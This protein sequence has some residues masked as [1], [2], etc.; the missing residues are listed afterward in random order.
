MNEDILK[1]VNDIINLGYFGYDDYG[2]YGLT[3]YYDREIKN[4]YAEKQ[5]F[6]QELKNSENKAEF[7]I[8]FSIDFAQ[9][10]LDELLDAVKKASSTEEVPADAVLIAAAA[11]V[12][13]TIHQDLTKDNAVFYAD[14]YADLEEDN[15]SWDKAYNRYLKDN[16]MSI[17][18]CINRVANTYLQKVNTKML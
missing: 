6:N 10:H 14:D 3:G 4:N 7:L 2:S 9:R 18:T 1:W 16:N 15:N 5:L 13:K 8:D 12:Y 11:E 17:H